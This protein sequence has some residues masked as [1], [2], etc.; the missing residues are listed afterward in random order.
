MFRLIET[1]SFQFLDLHLDEMNVKKLIPTVKTFLNNYRLWCEIVSVGYNKVEV[2]PQLIE[3]GGEHYD[4]GI[5]KT[6]SLYPCPI[7]R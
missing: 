4:I 3:V 6:E 5:A 7:Y 2:N 1:P